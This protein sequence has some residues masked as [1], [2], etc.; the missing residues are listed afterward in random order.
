MKVD[1]AA[2][3]FAMAG[4]I[5]AVLIMDLIIEAMIDWWII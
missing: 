5:V 4:A 3:S 2:V 1:Y